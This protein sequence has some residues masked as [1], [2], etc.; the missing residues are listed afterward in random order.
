L[1]SVEEALKIVIRNSLELK[2]TEKSLADSFGFVL[3]EDIVAE[4]NI[5][6]FNNSAMDGYAIKAE[7]SAVGEKL[8]VIEELPAGTVAGKP[9]NQGQASVIMTGAPLPLGAD[10]VIEVESTEKSGPD[11]ILN[12][13]VK[14]NENVRFAGEDIKA[15]DK[16]V[17]KG[18][19]VNSV[20]MGV[21]ASLGHSK[22]NVYKKPSVS[23]LSTGS[24]LVAQGEDLVDGKIRDSNSLTLTGQCLDIGITPDVVGIAK[25]S[26]ADTE[27]KLR[28]ALQCQV[29]LTTGGVSVGEYDFVKE[30]LEDMGAEKLFWGVNQK[31]GKPLAFYKIDDKVIFALPG[32]PVA[33]LVCFEVYVRPFLL[34]SMGFDNILKPLIMV[35]AGQDI[36]KKKHRSS[37][38]RVNLKEDDGTLKAYLSGPQG[39]GILTSMFAEGLMYLNADTD[40]IN[41][42][43]E[44][45]VMM[46]HG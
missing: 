26:K 4:N 29:V 32:N 10:S 31:P 27:N 42:G 2:I 6:P 1:I 20:V 15:G 23:I 28:K 40:S 39:S 34:R 33:V 14:K 44:V 18:T 22:L 38:L 17:G 25:D 43:D 37:W 3:T 21:A 5:P 9:V 35:K 30:V 7:D 24:E 36:K 46:F 11:V 12:R 45:E 16:V 41:E 19:V 13:Q 8:K